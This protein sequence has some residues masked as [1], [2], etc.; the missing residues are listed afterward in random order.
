LC[1]PVL[2]GLVCGKGDQFGPLAVVEEA[3]DQV[4]L[5][6]VQKWGWR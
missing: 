4:P 6:L 3:G 2:L 1:Y 5:V